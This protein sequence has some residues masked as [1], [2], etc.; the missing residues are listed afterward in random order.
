MLS[1]LLTWNLWTYQPNV[2]GFENKSTQEV[3]LSPSKEIKDIVKIDQILFNTD[4]DY[5]GTTSSEKINFMMNDIST[6]K[7]N[8]FITGTKRS[9]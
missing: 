2:E 5:Y 8:G 7:F 6:W 9:D 1:G 3:M 4:G